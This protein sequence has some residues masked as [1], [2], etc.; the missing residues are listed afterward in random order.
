MMLD[1]DVCE[2][3]RLARDPRFDGRFFVA[4]LTTGIYCRPICPVRAPKP[5]NVR[6]YPSAAAAAEA[7]FRPCLRCRPEASP[8]TPAWLGTAATVSRALRLIADG[9]LDQGSVEELATR[10]GVGAR[11]LTRLFQR[12]LGAS[13]LA[14]A[15]N[16]RLLFAKTLISDTDLSMAQV[17]LAAGFGSIRRFNAVFRQTYGCAPSSLRKARRRSSGRAMGQ[18][19]DFL[20][21][22]PFRPPFDWQAIIDFLGPRAI[23]GVER[24][25]ADFYARTIVLDGQS[26]WIVVRPL[27]DQS[28][29]ELEVDFQEPRALYKIVERV[30]QIFD[31]G[32]DPAQ[33]AAHLNQ[34][35]KLAPLIAANPGLR[36]PG[37]WDCF[38]LAV[39]AVLGQ[40]VTV[41]GASTLAGRLVQTFGETASRGQDLG[42][43]HLFPTE[44]AM[45]AG[46]PAQIGMP[47]AR[48]KALRGLAAAVRDGRVVFD[49]ALGV[50]P[51]E[52]QLT[53]LPGLGSW[54]AQY[55]AMRALNEPDAFPASD[56]G[57][58]RAAERLGL[59]KTPRELAA[60]AESWRPWR[61]YAAM[62]LWRSEAAAQDRAT[63]K[64]KRKMRPRK[65]EHVLQASG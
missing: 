14:V 44:S 62:H 17:A 15:K 56:L 9:A 6:F 57:L 41:K 12:H 45:A 47:H 32:A 5:Q 3:A 8:G 1:P 60:L 13:P 11:H 27:P 21:R 63:T 48:G 36:L 59:A 53:T 38:E 22:L 20:L 51:L 61:A 16:R 39:R 4:V 2:R 43:T 25:E 55:V 33:I 54:T 58:L 42:L 35:V 31:L 19:G 64:A 26:G 23:P 34:D 7:G 40:Q 37:A 10:L 24:V 49:T 18:N 30:R 28:Y 65:E 52:E 46:E 29:L 50:E